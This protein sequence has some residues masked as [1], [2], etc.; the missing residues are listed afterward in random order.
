ME[1]QACVPHHCCLKKNIFGS[2]VPK[3]KWDSC[4]SLPPWYLCACNGLANSAFWSPFCLAGHAL[5]ENTNHAQIFEPYLCLCHFM[6]SALGMSF[7]PC[8]PRYYAMVFD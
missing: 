4:L 3:K 5:G 8:L 2:L 7:M 1:M 6:V